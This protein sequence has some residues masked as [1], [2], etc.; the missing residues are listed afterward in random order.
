MKTIEKILEY[1]LNT[2]EIYWLKYWEIINWCWWKG[3]QDFNKILKDNL[4]LIKWFDIKKQ[5]YLFYDIR[6]ICDEHD[7]EFRFKKWFYMSNFRFAKKIYKL[8]TLAKKKWI[9]KKEA[10][11]IASIVFVLLN[12]FWKEF[13]FT[14][15]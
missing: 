12:R 2:K 14:K 15:K 4:A 13:Y 7:V 11:I 10:F 3:W 6:L 9:T 8:L 5:N 1:N